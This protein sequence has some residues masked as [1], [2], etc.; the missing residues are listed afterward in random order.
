VPVVV[1]VNGVVSNFGS[2]AIHPSGGS[3]SDSLS[4]VA[5]DLERVSRNELTRAGGIVLNAAEYSAPGIQNAPGRSGVAGGFGAVNAASMLSSLGPMGFMN[6]LP[7]TSLGACYVYQGGGT[8]AE[9][10]DR[11]PAAD[12][13]AGEAIHVTSPLGAFD[14]A[15][16]TFG[17]GI[18]LSEDENVLLPGRYIFDNTPGGAD[19]GPFENASITIPQSEYTWTNR[20]AIEAVPRAQDLVITWTGGEE[21]QEIVLIVGF[22]ARTDLNVMGMYMCAERM[23]AGQFTV[24]AWLLSTLPASSPWNILS[25]DDPP[26]GLYVGRISRLDLNR[27]TAPGLDSGYLIYMFADLR[28]VPYE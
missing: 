8:E 9:I 28:V 4:F 18:E 22:S 12:V 1:I 11:T 2:I 23:N 7:S 3:C 5:A 13:D 6:D 26:S 27:L 21:D 16:G 17:Y 24:P 10:D 19:I 14:M 20:D 15:S 25:E